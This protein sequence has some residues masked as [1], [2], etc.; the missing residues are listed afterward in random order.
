MATN[1]NLAITGMHCASCAAIIQRT[2]KKTPGVEESNVNYAAAKAKVLF[3]PTKADIAAIIAAIKSAGYGAEVAGEVDREKERAKRS[4]EVASYRDRFLLGAALSAPLLGFM[5][6]MMFAEDSTLNMAL[7]PWMPIAS[8]LFSAPVQFWLGA[9]FFHSAWAALRVRTFNM[10]SLVAIGTLTAYVY[11]LYE[12]GVGTAAAGTPFT[13]M[14]NLYFEV[15]ALLITFVLLGKWLEARAKGATSDAIQKLMAM[16]AK[17]AR[18]KRGGETVEIPI[19]Q[20]A[21]GDVVVV[22]P[23]EKIPVDGVV[24]S[25]LTSVDESM[26]TGESI[27]VEKKDGDRVYGATMNKNGSIEFRAEKIGGDTALAQIIR[28]VEDAQGSKAPIQDFADWVS[29]WFVP[30][31]IAIALVTL[32]GWLLAGA[33]LEYSLL[34]FVSVIVIACPCALGLATPTSIMVATGK[35]A[36]QGILIRGGEPLEAARTVD[37][38]VFDKTGTLTKGKPDV[39]DIAG[40]D[41]EERHVLF[42]AASLEQ[43]S[44]HPLA[45][46]IVDHAKA[47]GVKPA[48]VEGFL[49]VPGHGIRG[50][51]EGKQYAFGNR[52]LMEKEGVPLGDVEAR[53]AGLE[54]EGKTVMILASGGRIVGNVAVADTIKD[55]SAAAVAMLRHMGIAAVMITGDNRRTAE[56]IARLAGIDRV[57]AEVL[58]EQKAAE[59]KKLQAAGSV[60]AMVGDG[61]ND[62]PALAQANLGIAMGSGSDIAMETGGIVLVKNDLRDVAA[63]IALSRETVKKI[64]QNLFFAL[65]YNVIGIP[66][67]ARLF[68]HWG[69][70]LRPELAGLAMALSSVSVVSNALL[71][72]GFRADRR[73]W[74]SDLA[75]VAMAVGFGALFFFAAKAA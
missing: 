23:G 11:S 29:S 9:P 3:D 37:T 54:S 7:A 51:V 62:S 63:A 24:T 22:R 1:V 26:L 45:Q 16:Q 48:P 60:V 19:D 27:P 66:V 39:T 6:L 13:H 58:P 61:I 36:E 64:W 74:L 31:V 10:D 17:T 42:V 12:F 30:A 15:S 40:F 14:D 68:A 34:A 67:A 52:R 59:I 4:A 70:E 33:T 21:V 56:A 47:Q 46:S 73:N 53:I 5:L 2:L 69:I 43:G 50:T 71:L 65:F 20:V 72:K 8:L 25:G 55:T 18:V 41:A 35:G 44:E 32:V 49:A 38:I 75:P 57:L 28:F